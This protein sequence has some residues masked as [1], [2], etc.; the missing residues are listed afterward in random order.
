MKE[1]D[2]RSA[3]L[4]LALAGTSL[5]EDVRL[6][7]LLTFTAQTR[8]TDLAGLLPEEKQSAFKEWLTSSIESTGLTNTVDVYPTWIRTDP[9]G[10]LAHAESILAVLFESSDNRKAQAIVAA[11]I[12]AAE[13]WPDELIPHLLE[14]LRHYE[15]KTFLPILASAA[16]A[17]KGVIAPEIF[18]RLVSSKDA[19]YRVVATLSLE[20]VASESQLPAS[21]PQGPEVR[22]A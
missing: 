19:E 21:G 7:L 14:A 8:G 1:R 4:L 9:S 13:L 15:D 10:C 12:A 11:G 22:S 3:D 6:T 17:R 5:T 18:Q 20:S 16:R 2:P